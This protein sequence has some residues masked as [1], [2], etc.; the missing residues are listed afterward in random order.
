MPCG[1]LVLRPSIELARSSN[2]WTAS[3]FLTASFFKMA[4]GRRSVLQQ[5]HQEH[6]REDSKGLLLIV[7]P[8]ARFLVDLSGCETLL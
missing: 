6:H 3:Q 5:E 4:V 1:I 2:L 8:L 7:D